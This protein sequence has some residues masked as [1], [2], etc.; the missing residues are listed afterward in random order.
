MVA[1]ICCR[2]PSRPEDVAELRLVLEL[3]AVRGLA[4]RGLSDQ[5]LAL[6]KRLAD[7][8]LRAARS[9]DVLSYLQADVVFHLCLLQ[10]TGDAAL[11]EIARLLVAR[12]PRR[13]P[14]LEELSRLMTRE[15]R[16]HVELASMLGDGMVSAA[17]HLLRT[18]LSRLSAGGPAPARLLG[19]EHIRCQGA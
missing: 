13:S 16:E 19:P 6:V 15:A 9:G 4:D 5:E 14:R 18:H 7:A 17:D 10:L 2:Y 1:S 3:P 11:A 12:D 8:T